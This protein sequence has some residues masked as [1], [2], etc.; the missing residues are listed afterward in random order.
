MTKETKTIKIVG[1]I[2]PDKR[3]GN[4]VIFTRDESLAI[5]IKEKII[6]LLVSKCDCENYTEVA[7]Q[8]LEIVKQE[9]KRVVEEMKKDIFKTSGQIIMPNGYNPDNLNDVV[10]CAN[11]TIMETYNQAL[12]EILNKIKNL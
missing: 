7:D 6:D 1:E 10:F 8:L 2:V 12:T 4:K 3:L 5:E 11:N 9:F